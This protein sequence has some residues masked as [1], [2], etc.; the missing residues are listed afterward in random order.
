VLYEIDLRVGPFQPD[1][2]SLGDFESC[3]PLSLKFHID[4]PLCD[5]ERDYDISSPSFA[6]AS[7]LDTSISID[8]LEDVLIIPKPLTPLASLGRLKESVEYESDA[9]VHDHDCE[10]WYNYND[11][12][13]CIVEDTPLGESCGMLV[14]EV[15][16]SCLKLIEY[17]S[18]DSFDLI[19][20]SLTCSLRSPPLEHHSASLW[21]IM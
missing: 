6:Y 8:T 20:T 11:Y 3:P 16:P 12:E 7:P 5:F 10:G 2:C 21:I 14:H 15:P 18:P 17:M 4:A 1:D 9:S 19:P 13:K